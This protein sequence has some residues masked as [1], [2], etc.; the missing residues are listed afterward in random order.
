MSLATKGPSEMDCTTDSWVCV[1][2][3]ESKLTL[4]GIRSEIRTDG[5]A[6]GLLLD[7]LDFTRG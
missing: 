2:T 1:V 7:Q 6:E 5:D 4:A 3:A